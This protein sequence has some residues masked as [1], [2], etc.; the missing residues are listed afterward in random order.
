M[1]SQPLTKYLQVPDQGRVAYDVHGAGPLVLLVPGMGELR[2]T[3]RFLTPA[4]VAAG[5]TVATTD[6]RGHG[7]S[8]AMFTS[9]GGVATA[10]DIERLLR[11]L[12]RPAVVVGSSMA[13]GSAVIVAA[14]HPELIRG[15]VLVGPF[16]RQPS[17][18]AVMALL[19]RVLTARPWAA[20]VW[21]AYMP[22][23]YAGTKPLDFKEYRQDA[24]KSMK[25][26]GY[27]RAFSQTTR[28]DHVRAG[29]CLTSVA[30]PTL[31]V[32]GEKDP[33]FKDPR[34]EAEWIGNTL[35]GS[36]V[37]V[38]DAGHYPHSQQPGDTSAAIVDFLSTLGGHA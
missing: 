24:I 2:S 36:V 5:Y 13:A 35:H 27:A 4:L 10:E 23:L 11:E 22:A 33:D 32:M 28:T 16:V 7:D 15:L 37:M 20:A 21:K 34:T 6:L 31:V 26:P 12:G 17:T 18:N 9:F 8:D 3:Y 29:E 19:F 1:S 38:A 25:R 14:E 30:A